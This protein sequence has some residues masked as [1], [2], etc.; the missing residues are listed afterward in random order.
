MVKHQCPADVKALLTM[1]FHHCGQQ[2]VLY[3]IKVVGSNF[4]EGAQ[5]FKKP[6]KRGLTLH[7]EDQG[8]AMVKH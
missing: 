4:Q 7:I 5:L 2:V 3:G 8:F 6:S 1:E